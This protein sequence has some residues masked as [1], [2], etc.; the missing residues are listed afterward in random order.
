LRSRKDTMKRFLQPAS[1][2]LMA[3]AVS[4]CDDAG[5]SI[6]APPVSLS[7]GIAC[8]K[9]IGVS[10]DPQ[11]YESLIRLD[12]GRI[13]FTCPFDSKTDH[14][15]V[16]YLSNGSPGCAKESLS[17]YTVSETT[18]LHDIR[19]DFARCSDLLSDLKEK[20]F[21]TS[22]LNTYVW[23]PRFGEG[24]FTRQRMLLGFNIHN[25]IAFSGIPIIDDAPSNVGL[26]FSERPEVR[27]PPSILLKAIGYKKPWWMVERKFPDKNCDT[28]LDVVVKHPTDAS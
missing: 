1:F 16:V 20:R 14:T 15:A 3:I 13:H 26:C 19:K 17:D 28:A 18:Y 6:T 22:H 24:V 7:A 25:A 11:L 9:V 5:P 21:Q 27:E 23:V 8:R 12:G 4:S 2:M 10:D